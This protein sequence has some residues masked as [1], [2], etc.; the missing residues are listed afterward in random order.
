MR[1]AASLG[2]EEGPV[3]SS[4]SARYLVGKLESANIPVGDLNSIFQ[5]ALAALSLA[6][7]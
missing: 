5:I 2:A 7:G 1:L 6:V 3:V 4:G